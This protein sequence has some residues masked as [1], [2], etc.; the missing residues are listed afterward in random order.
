MVLLFITISKQRRRKHDHD[1][2]IQTFDISSI[3]AAAALVLE[4]LHL[5]LNILHHIIIDEEKDQ[6]VSPTAAAEKQPIVLPL[7]LNLQFR[8]GSSS[9][10]SIPTKIHSQIQQLL[11]KEG[12][13]N[14]EEEE[15]SKTA[16]VVF[17][18]FRIIAAHDECI[19][20]VLPQQ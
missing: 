16:V 6:K 15:G 18:K 14:K 7:I 10:S 9:S 13:R 19:D 1:F 4:G 8:I 5:L 11:L 3:N 12:A 20:Y 2:E 17:K